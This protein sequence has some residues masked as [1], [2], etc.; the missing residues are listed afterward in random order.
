MERIVVFRILHLGA[1][2][3]IQLVTISY[4]RPK[5]TLVKE[6]RKVTKRKRMKKLKQESIFKY[7][8]IK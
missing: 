1:Q 8:E 5:G 6:K 4:K 7:V 3:A 2:N